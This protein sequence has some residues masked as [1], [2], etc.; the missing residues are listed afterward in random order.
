MKTIDECLKESIANYKKLTAKIAELSERIEV[1]KPE[2]IQKQC[3]SIRE[4]QEVV[5]EHEDK[6]C[7]IM[8]F[9]GR[10]TLDN[11]LVGEYQRALDSAIREAANIDSKARLRRSLLLKEIAKDEVYPEED[12]GDSRVVTKADALLH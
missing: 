9:I 5:V 3:A 2:E 8:S 4:L 1:L 12:S 10:E 6:L 7:H 11:P